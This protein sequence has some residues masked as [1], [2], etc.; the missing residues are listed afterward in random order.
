MTYDAFFSRAAEVMKESAI[1]RMGSVGARVPDLI[2]FAPGYPDPATFPWDDFQAITTELLYGTDGS[3]LQY[4][5]TRGFR[6]L[7][8]QL[9]TILA[10]R[11]IRSNFEDRLIT[12]G[13]QQ[14]LDLVGRVLVD[15]GDVVLVE[16]PT[17]TGAIAAFRNAQADLIGVP[18]EADGIDLEALD[19]TWARLTAAGRRVKFLYVVP[20]FQ[21]PTGLLIGLEKRRCLLD[22]AE[23]RDVL[24]V[25]DDPYCD[26]YFPDATTPD[27]TRPMKADDGAGRVIY[28]GSFS[29]TLAP[30]FRVAWVVAP[31]QIVAKLEIAKQATDICAGALDQRV[32]HQA[33][34]RGILH[35]QGERLRMHY[36]RKRTVMEE[37]LT[38]ELGGT[39]S[40]AIPRG[41][42]FLWATLGQGLEAEALLTYAIDARVTFVAGTAFY[43]DGG[44][45]S[46]LR[47]SFS[48]PTPE[49][50]AE[51]V[52]R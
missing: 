6:P 5:P 51:G 17:Y 18:Q 19:A 13:S 28:L 31:P 29:K 45:A 40:W 39:I 21:N 36:Q 34:V 9:D 35:A 26:L 47:L 25:E 1:R 7:L 24:V 2:S 12:T 11:G 49:R 14:G 23:R 20:N 33:A 3:V 48:Q 37:A 42:F 30:G 43:V 44:G 52:A 41:G 27:Q 50:L 8:E 22:W 38:R 10:A 4:G 16:L 15:P 32:V 46:T